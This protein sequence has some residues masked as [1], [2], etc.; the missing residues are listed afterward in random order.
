MSVH[1]SMNGG[2]EVKI[3]KKIK[4]RTFSHALFHRAPLTG[5]E[6]GVTPGSVGLLPPESSLWSSVPERRAHQP[7][8]SLFPL[9]P[10]C[11]GRGRRLGKSGTKCQNMSDI[12]LWSK[13]YFSI[14][15]REGHLTF[16]C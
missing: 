4:V 10:P 5:W 13:D 12:I 2:G 15:E 7:P 3:R 9:P 11:A 16:T 14:N 8:S 1:V 6:R